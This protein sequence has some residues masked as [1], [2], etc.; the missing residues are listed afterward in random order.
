MR[1]KARKYARDDT[2]R[3]RFIAAHPPKNGMYRCVYCGKKVSKDAM[4]VDHVIAVDRVKKNWLYR[5][6]VPSGINDLS[7]LVPSCHRCNSKKGNKGGFWA[8]RGHFWK[9]FLPIK[10]ITQTVF[11]FAL[12]LF[13]LVAILGFF[14][15]GPAAVWYASILSFFVSL[16]GKAISFLTD[17]G[18]MIASSASE[19]IRN[20]FLL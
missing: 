1:V 4:E 14:D 17:T 20:S 19:K 8:I 3:E 18:M 7:N 11:V 5:L 12:I 9:F 16:P 13:L 6:C 15:V 2:Y 10:I